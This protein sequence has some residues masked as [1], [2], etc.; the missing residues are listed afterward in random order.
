[1]IPARISFVTVGVHNMDK[2]RAFYAGLGWREMAQAEDFTAYDTGGAVLA[3]FALDSL[4]A[5]AGVVPYGV[6]PTLHGFALAINVEEA[7]MVDEVIEEVRAAGGRITTEPAD[8]AWGGRTAY[9]AD[10]E[11]NLWEVAWNPEGSFDARGTFVPSNSR[12]G[13]S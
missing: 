7:R 6:R 13:L 5:D 11:D 1:M 9:F 3:L 4:A 10:P 12:L 2:C 8:A